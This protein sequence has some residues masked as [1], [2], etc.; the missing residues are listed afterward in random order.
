MDSEQNQ[1]RTAAITAI[2]SFD[3][4]LDMHQ[5]LFNDYQHPNVRVATQFL[6]TEPKY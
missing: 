2:S 4:S 1:I 5:L 6:M 3:L